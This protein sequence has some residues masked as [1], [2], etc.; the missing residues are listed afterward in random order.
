MSGGSV[1]AS[2]PVELDAVLS[3]G[4]GASPCDFARGGQGRRESE[5]GVGG[6]RRRGREE[7]QDERGERERKG[8]AYRSAACGLP[9]LLR[10]LRDVR[11]ELD[12]GQRA[13]AHPLGRHAQVMPRVEGRE[14]G[15]GIHCTRRQRECPAERGELKGYVVCRCSKIGR[16]KTPRA[17]RRPGRMRLER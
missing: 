4:A 15:D 8:G 1:L 5:K 2:S 3:C 13:L 12:P 10:V 9:V 11:A 7:P 14:E 16:R 6:G 17:R